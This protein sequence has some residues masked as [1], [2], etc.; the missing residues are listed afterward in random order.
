MNSRRRNSSS[1]PTSCCFVFWSAVDRRCV[2]AV[3]SVLFL[4]FAL[5]RKAELLAQENPD[6]PRVLVARAECTVRF[7]CRRDRC[8]SSPAE[9]QQNRRG[10]RAGGG[11]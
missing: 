1:V 7:D 5:R 3:V 6:N 11:S 9:P 2:L 4:C 10:P 8:G